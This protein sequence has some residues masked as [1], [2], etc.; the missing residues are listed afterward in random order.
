M[1]HSFFKKTRKI[2]QGYFFS[3][4]TLL[5]LILPLF[6]LCTRTELLKLYIFLGNERRNYGSTSNC[7]Q[8]NF[9]P[10]IPAPEAK[11]CDYSRDC[12]KI[13]CVVRQ[14]PDKL[15]VIL[16]LNTCKVPWNA[17][18]TLKQPESNLNWS[19]TLKDG[20][21]A[22]LDVTPSMLTGGIPVSNASFFVHVG[23]RKHG[24][25]LLDYTVKTSK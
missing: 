15:R 3:S 9:L 24:E 16:K 20:E 23:L 21:K 13:D 8:T 10:S 17:T 12:S 4:L 7:P 6:V 5:A 18:V 1:F 11:H 22:K 2:Y 25:Q 19:A 14:D